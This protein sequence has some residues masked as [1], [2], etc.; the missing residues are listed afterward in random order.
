MDIRRFCDYVASTGCTVKE[1]LRLPVEISCTVHGFPSLTLQKIFDKPDYYLQP[2]KS[3]SFDV[4]SVDIGTNDLCDPSITSS[5][6]LNLIHHFIELLTQNW[7]QPKHLVFSSIIQ[8][9]KISRQNQVSLNNFNHRIKFNQSFSDV[10][11]SILCVSLF[12]QTVLNFRSTFVMMVFISP[13]K[14]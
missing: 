5:E 4:I 10:F 6:L 9:K 13:R 7:I 1:V 11:K 14:D 8:R 12:P 3:N 2:L